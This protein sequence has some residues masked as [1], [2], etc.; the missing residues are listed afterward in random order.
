[1]LFVAHDDAQPEQGR[2]L[3]ASTRDLVSD[4][5]D[6]A[7]PWAHKSWAHDM[8]TDAR[9][10]REQSISLHFRQ[11]RETLDAAIGDETML[12]AMMEIADVMITSLHAG[13]KLLVAGN[14]GSA[15]DA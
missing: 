7:R 6:A 14:G 5:R 15:A 10:L 4:R 1:M 13:N 2:H 12:R 3:N 11:S 9:G 8:T